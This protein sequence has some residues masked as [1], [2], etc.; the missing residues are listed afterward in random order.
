MQKEQ[1]IEAITEL[2][3]KCNKESVF[4]FVLA[5]LRKQ[6]KNSVIY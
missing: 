3:S 5:F 4:S 6:E 2:L 1:Y